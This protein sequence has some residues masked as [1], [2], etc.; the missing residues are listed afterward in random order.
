MD[1]ILVVMQVIALAALVV[2]A[3]SAVTPKAVVQAVLVGMGA[4]WK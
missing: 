4:R 3:H 2:I 1:A